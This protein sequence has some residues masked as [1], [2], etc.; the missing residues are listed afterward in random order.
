MSDSMVDGNASRAATCAAAALIDRDLFLKKP[1]GWI[2]SS[3]LGVSAI[4]R[5]P[6]VGNSLHRTGVTLFTP[7]SV[8]CAARMVAASSC[9]GVHV[10]KHAPRVGVHCRKFPEQHDEDFPPFQNRSLREYFTL[11][12]NGIWGFE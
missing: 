11:A 8:V 4:A 9:Q 2:I 7:A 3:S 5:S 6:G 12:Q 10:I 1:R